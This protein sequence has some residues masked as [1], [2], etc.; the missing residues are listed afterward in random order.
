MRSSSIVVE[1][2]LATRLV[3]LTNDAPRREA[4]VVP[5]PDPPKEGWVPFLSELFR[6]APD[7]QDTKLA[8]LSTAFMDLSREL[9]Q[10][11]GGYWSAAIS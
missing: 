2:K 3:A 6:I 5:C 11:S 1:V 4:L 9:L 7:D 8:P 10:R